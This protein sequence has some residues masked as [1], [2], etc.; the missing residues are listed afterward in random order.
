MNIYVASSWRNERQPVIAEFLRDGGHHVYHF[1]HPSPGDD[2]FQWSDIDPDWER[3]SPLAFRSFLNQHDVL[4][5]YCNNFNA[6][7]AADVC[8]LVLPCGSSAHLEAGWFVGAGRPVLALLADGEPELMYKM[9]TMLCVDRN[10][11]AEALEVID[12]R[13]HEPLGGGMFSIPADA[14]GGPR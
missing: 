1:R 11:L 9:F 7:R 10:E 13:K 6:M 5:A 8:V 14:H 12:R 4:R 2:G 3:W